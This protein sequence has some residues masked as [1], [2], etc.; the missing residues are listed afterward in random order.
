MN[1][2]RK[3]LLLTRRDLICNRNKVRYRDF[4]IYSKNLLSDQLSDFIKDNYENVKIVKFESPYEA[5][6]YLQHNNYID[7]IIIQNT[8]QYIDGIEVI[9]R[10]QYNINSYILL[11]SSLND[12][13]VLLQDLKLKP[14]LIQTPIDYNNLK[15]L[16][17]DIFAEIKLY[18]TNIV[19]N[20]IS[21]MLGKLMFK[22]RKLLDLKKIFLNLVCDTDDK[23]DIYSKIESKTNIPKRT[24]IDKVATS[25]HSI[26]P[27]L[28]YRLGLEKPPETNMEFLNALT[29]LIRKQSIEEYERLRRVSGEDE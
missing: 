16:L 23:S 18:E 22:G 13:S 9:R 26:D 28:F 5:I 15:I 7:I 3:V 11:I 19:E 20:N 25:F 1:I 6:D 8:L 24:V 2:R 27:E 4:D 17:D 14:V 21:E 10:V 29:E 12:T